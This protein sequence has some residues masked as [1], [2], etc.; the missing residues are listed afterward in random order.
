MVGVRMS[1]HPVAKALV[2]QVG[3]PIVA[4]S[5]NRSGEP[6]AASPEDC[7]NAGLSWVTGL[8][9]GGRVRGSAST[10]VGLAGGDL[11][12]HRLGPVSAS[13]LNAVWRPARDR[14]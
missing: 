9:K 11:V 6:A 5:A 8:L 10:V 7:D 13:Q 4:T 1:A 12:I 3:V 14:H 2:E